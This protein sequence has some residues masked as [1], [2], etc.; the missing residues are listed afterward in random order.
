MAE[1]VRK[2]VADMTDK[3]ALFSGQFTRQMFAEHRLRVE[4]LCRAESD[5]R[6]TY[7][8]SRAVL[9]DALGACHPSDFDCELF[10]YAC[11]CVTKR[12]AHLIAAGL[13][14]L[15]I[16]HFRPS[17]TAVADD[18]APPSAVT[19]AMAGAVFEAHPK[20]ATM[21]ACKARELIDGRVPFTLRP[22]D[23]GERGACVMA[24]ILA[25]ML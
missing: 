1:L 6:G 25:G 18:C 23:R 5:A 22:V 19:V 16:R 20:Y 24:G 17:D 8:G 15:L 4:H 2:M 7:A 3:N 11:E 21:V 13:A 14:G 9:T 12:S 10:R